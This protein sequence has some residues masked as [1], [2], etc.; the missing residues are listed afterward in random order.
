MY[1]LP[2][3]LIATKANCRDP[4]IE[5]H[6]A[7]EEPRYRTK[8]DTKSM[9]GEQEKRE[10][11]C[12]DAKEWTCWIGKEQ[13]VTEWQ[14]QEPQSTVGVQTDEIPYSS[15]RKC[16]DVTY[17]QRLHPWWLV[18]LQQQSVFRWPCGCELLSRCQREWKTV[19][20]DRCGL[21]HRTLFDYPLFSVGLLDSL[22]I[23]NFSMLNFYLF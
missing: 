18:I 9:R 12:G 17:R 22:F 2:L 1:F 10:E 21:C 14:I 4:I 23:L 16:Y 8:R 13:N 6:E 19:F 11:K 5:W 15:E 3:R 20:H 7:Q